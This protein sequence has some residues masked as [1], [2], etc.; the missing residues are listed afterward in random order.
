[1]L[2][3]QAVTYGPTLSAE[4]QAIFNRATQGLDPS[5]MTK[6]H[7]VDAIKLVKD[8]GL[9]VAPWLRAR[10]LRSTLAFVA[11]A[12]IPGGEALDRSETLLKQTKVR[13]AIKHLP[14]HA[15]R[16]HGEAV[17]AL[18]HIDEAQGQVNLDV[19]REKGGMTRA[20][21]RGSRPHR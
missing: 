12:P 19:R 2:K 11:E 17:D 18:A 6:Q 7:I 8:D 13:R 9:D 16:Q 21:R 4:L 3:S 10:M 20:S 1:M 5:S 15:L 14:K